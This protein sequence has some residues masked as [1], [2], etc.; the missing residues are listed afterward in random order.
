M[1]QVDDQAEHGQRTGWNQAITAAA[2]HRLDPHA[3][4]RGQLPP[5][6]RRA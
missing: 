6:R 4:A 3:Q 5:R 2:K 1:A